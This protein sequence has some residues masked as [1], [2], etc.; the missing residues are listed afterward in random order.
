MAGLALAT[1][2]AVVLAPMVIQEP[3]RLT[4][5]ASAAVPAIQLAAAVSPQEI[6]N[7]LEG[8]V[9]TAVAGAAELAMFPAN[10]LIS[11]TLAAQNTSFEVFNVLINAT[12]DAAL[13]ALLTGL[14]GLQFGNLNYL[15]NTAYDIQGTSQFWADDGASLATDTANEAI[16]ATVNS[17][18]GVLS[19]PLAVSSYTSLLGAAVK[20]VFDSAGNLVWFANDL[21]QAPLDLAD[22]AFAALA[23]DATYS[24]AAWSD[25]VAATLTTLATQTGVPFI[26]SLTQGLLAITTTP[27]SILA[28]GLGD[29]AEWTPVFPAVIVPEQIVYAAANVVA[30]VFYG[31]SSIGD[32]ITT[33][34]AAPLDPA[35]YITSLQGFVTAGFNAGSEAIWSVNQVAQIGPFVFNSVVNPVAIAADTLTSAV[36]HAAS[37][38]LSAAGAPVD[39]VNAPIIFAANAS[40]AIWNAADGVLNGSAEVANWLQ[41]NAY[42]L[43]DANNTAGEEINAWLGGLVGTGVGPGVAARAASAPAG[44]VSG[45]APGSTA[46]VTPTRDGAAFGQR[47]ARH[48]ASSAATKNTKAAPALAGS[49]KAA[50]AGSNPRG[51]RS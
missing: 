16:A 8:V 26:E 46:A 3:P 32:A 12:N 19:T 25:F 11:A 33:I 18:A 39:A 28:T 42:Q 17:V 2:S 50:A 36:A 38:L 51:A 31:L 48:R 9:D 22:T 1:V 5:S 21:I 14:Q 15:V 40:N 30:P 6:I 27:L 35:S 44:L 41:D 45:I 29:L 49:R 20:T 47:S 4:F 34:G 13:K 24:I 7:A 10:A 37:G 43:M 23:F